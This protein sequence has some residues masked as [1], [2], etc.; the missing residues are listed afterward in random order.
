MEPLLIM[1]TACVLLAV[2][3]LGGGRVR[4]AARG[5]L[6][7]NASLSKDVWTMRTRIALKTDAE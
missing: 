1:K 7:G 5:D 4:A 6:G 3:A 2:T